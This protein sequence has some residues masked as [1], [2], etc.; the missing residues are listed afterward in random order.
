LALWLL[1]GGAGIAGAGAFSA[2]GWLLTLGLAVV[3]IALFWWTR[4]RV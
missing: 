3:A 1:I 4:R 2:S